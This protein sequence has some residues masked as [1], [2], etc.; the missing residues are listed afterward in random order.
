MGLFNE[1]KVIWSMNGV[2]ALNKVTC[3]GW[4]Y[5]FFLESLRIKSPLKFN[6]NLKFATVPGHFQNAVN[7]AKFLLTRF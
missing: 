1:N 7:I 2:Y 4:I 3:E 6:N 5:L